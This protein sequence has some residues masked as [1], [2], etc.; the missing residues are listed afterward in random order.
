MKKLGTIQLAALA[1]MLLIVSA[2]TNSGDEVADNNDKTNVTDMAEQDAKHNNDPSV[3]PSETGDKKQTTSKDGNVNEGIG[4]NIYSTIGSSG[5]HEGGI[6]SFFESILEG[7][8]ITG[9]KVFVV[10]DSVIL[11]R[12]EEQTTS[13]EYDNRQR[14]LLSGTSGLSGKSNAQ[15]EGNDNRNVSQDNLDQAK[16]EINRMFNENVKILTVTNPEAVDTIETIKDNIMNSSYQEAS[17]NLLK[18]FEMAD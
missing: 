18:L 16:Q 3:I 2:C 9:V 14:D 12:N 8:G 13:H 15:A 1:G 4:Q 6:S 5:V 11:A 7:K 17:D 10:D